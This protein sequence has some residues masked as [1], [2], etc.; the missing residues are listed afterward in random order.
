MNITFRQLRVFDEVARQ[1]SMNG[2]AAVLHLTPQ[3]VSMQ[4]KEIETQLD[5]QLFDRQVRQVVLSTAGEYFLVHAR[6]MLGALKEA[7]DTVARFKRLEQGRLTVG[8][9]SSASCFV[10]QLH[11]APLLSGLP[12]PGRD[13]TSPTIGFRTPPQP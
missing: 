5:L 1:G 2:A 12:L 13:P 3:A 10:P 8:L 7:E 4:I 11:D 6:R 9:V